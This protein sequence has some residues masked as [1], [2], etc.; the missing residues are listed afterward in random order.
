MKPNALRERERAPTR[1]NKHAMIAAELLNV[2]LLLARVFAR[3]L[4]LAP[5]Y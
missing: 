2:T 4:Y 1:F 5:V 3:R